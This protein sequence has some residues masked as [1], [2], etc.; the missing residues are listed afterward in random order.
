MNWIKKDKF[1]SNIVKTII[2]IVVGVIISVIAGYILYK[3][4]IN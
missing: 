3:L 2:E 4:N 1:S